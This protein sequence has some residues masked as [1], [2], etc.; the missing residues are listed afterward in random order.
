MQDNTMLTVAASLVATLFGLL[1][2]LVGYM[3]SSI[4][5]ELKAMREKLNEV[6]SELHARITGLDMRITRIETKIEDNIK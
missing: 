3:G 5:S 2:M 1:V 6:A 4:I